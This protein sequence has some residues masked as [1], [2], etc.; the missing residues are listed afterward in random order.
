MTRPA[1]ARARCPWWALLAALPLLAQARQAEQPAAAAIAVNGFGT[2]GAVH[3][4]EP[5]A[6]FVFDNLQPHGAGRSRHWSMDTDSRLGVQLTM[7]ATPQLSAVVQV[8]SE[9]RADGS[10]TPFVSWANV[11]YAFTPDLSVRVGRIALASFLA[12]DSRRVGFSNV[13]ARP[14]SEV[15]RLLAV[16]ESDGVDATYRWHDGDLNNST[17][18]TYGRRTVTNVAGAD[19]HSTR[20]A[21]VFDTLDYGALTVHA[22]YQIRDVDNQHPPLGRFMSAGASYDPGPWFAQAEWARAV[23]Y[24]AASV[25][26][27]R[28]AWYVSA[29]MRF[30]SVAP[31]A[32]VS[33]LRPLSETGL[34]P[35][36]QRTYAGGIRWDV[37]RN[38]DLKLQWDRIALGDRSFGTLQNVAP[39]TRAGGR[40][41]VVSL[42]A[43]VIF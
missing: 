38:V 26:V 20:L 2:L 40:L 42:L 7:H 30:G 33:E 11:K 10:Y 27:A 23:N 12:S 17:S 36:A 13:S 6:D 24:T 41:H 43:D 29:G 21:G 34:A 15:Y 39:G 25:R 16:K 8:I 4:N 19:I 31:Y 22:A 3:S 18:V 28:A 5:R 9:Y 1:T 14:P 37:A 32:T 35:L